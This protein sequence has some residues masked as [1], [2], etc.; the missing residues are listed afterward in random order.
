[1][2]HSGSAPTSAATCSRARSS[3]S[4]GARPARAGS[5]GSPPARP[6]RAAWPPA[7]G[8]PARARPR[9][10]GRRWARS[11][12]LGEAVGEDGRQ[13][14]LD[15]RVLGRRD[16]VGRPAELDRAPPRGGTSAQAA[17]A[18]PSRGWPTAPGFTSHRPSLRSS[19]PSAGTPGLSM[20]PSVVSRQ[21][22]GTCVWPT[23]VSATRRYSRATRACSVVRT[24]SHTGSRGLPWKSGTAPPVSSGL[25]R[26][27]ARVPREPDRLAGPHQRRAG[28]VREHRQLRAPAGPHV[29]VAG[30]AALGLAHR[31]LDAVARVGPV[32]HQVAQ[33]PPRSAPAS[34]AARSVASSAW[35]LPWMSLRIATGA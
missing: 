15:D 14:R 35:R 21:A 32:A 24:Y 5:R 22:K 23:R 8:G 25:S 3:A 16:V 30:D 12:A 9:G 28:A 11:P 33:A 19:R 17:R 29:V 6:G 27:Q 31:H 10:R 20:V 4:A 13:A 18:S 2:I 1:M 34:R 7:P 26:Q